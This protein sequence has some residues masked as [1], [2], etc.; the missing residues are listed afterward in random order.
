MRSY[1]YYSDKYTSLLYR[2]EFD[3]FLWQAKFSKP[4]I[5]L[6]HNLM[7]GSLTRANK[8]ANP[9]IVTPIS[10][11]HESGLMLNHLFRVN[12]GHVA[13]INL[14]AGAFYHWTSSFNWQKNAVWV[15]GLSAGF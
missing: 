13:Y 12:F 1:D 15:M 3:K 2:H 7:Y 6:S 14:N 11:Y 10:G 8:L 4:F 9:E 5:G